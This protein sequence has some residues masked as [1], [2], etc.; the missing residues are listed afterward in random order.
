MT[1]KIS[2]Y[3]LILLVANFIFSAF[4]ISLP[5]IIVHA[6]GQNSWLVPIFL[7]P[8]FWLIVYLIF[9]NRRHIEAIKDLFAIGKKSRGLEKFFVL[10]FLLFVLISFLGDMRA[11][12]DFVASVLLPSTPLDIL[13][14]LSIFI[15][16]Y[17]SMSGLEVIARINGIHFFILMVIVLSLPLIL[18]NEWQPGNLKPLPSLANVMDLIKSAYFTFS[19][20]GQMILFLII[21]ASVNPLKE[22][23]KAVVSGTALGCFLVFTII[24]L[25]IM[26]LGTDIVKETTYPT[27]ILI[28]QISI[29]DF[30]DR[31]DLVL[32]SVWVPAMLTKLAFMLYAINYCLG[33]FYKSNTN[34]FLFPISI[35]LGYLSL[36]LFKNSM[37]HTHF[38]FYSWTSL[39]L[40]LEVLLIFLFLLVRRSAT[41]RHN[42]VAANSS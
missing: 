17:I 18:L 40:G 13:M 11:L 34:K 3:Q 33:F 26:V 24:M 20:L 14:V 27:Y 39:G 32:V 30:L 12:L 25:Q 37:E 23:R 41:K 21:I 16:V 9:G 1:Q 2:N 4:I 22:A 19:W 10:V 38:S 29:T 8:V 42:K 7:F 5:Q 15:I 35:L 28:Q 6:G 36:L 31:L